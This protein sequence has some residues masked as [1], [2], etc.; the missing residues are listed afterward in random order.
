VRRVA[1]VA[2]VRRRL[3]AAEPRPRSEHVVRRRPVLRG[4]GAGRLG[5]PVQPIP[6]GPAVEDESAP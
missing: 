5:L 4:R 3:G 2:V 6:L 1:P